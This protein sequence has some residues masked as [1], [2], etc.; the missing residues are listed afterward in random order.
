MWILSTKIGKEGKQTIVINEINH[1]Q[2]A[3][4]CFV[5]KQI[6]HIN[7]NY[8]YCGEFGKGKKID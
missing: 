1:M 7:F 5:R 2:K 3:L 4:E 6:I 8:F